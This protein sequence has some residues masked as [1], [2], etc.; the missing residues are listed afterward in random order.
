MYGRCSTFANVKACAG[1]IPS[2]SALSKYPENEHFP[3]GGQSCDS[4]MYLEF[5]DSIIAEDIAQ[6]DNVL[7]LEPGENFHLP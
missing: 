2:W 5:V 1:H 6:I 4:A 3:V 7:M